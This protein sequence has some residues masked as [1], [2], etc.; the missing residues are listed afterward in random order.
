[1]LHG[2]RLI[3]V[4]S[5]AFPPALENFSVGRGLGENHE[6]KIFWD[7]PAQLYAFE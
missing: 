3:D 1:M 4:D 5:R 7:N 6:R 2:L